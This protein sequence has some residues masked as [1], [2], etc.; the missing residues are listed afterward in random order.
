MQPYA[1]QDEARAKIPTQLEAFYKTS[2]PAV[3]ATK[4]ALV[5]A[6]GAELR[7]SIARTCFPT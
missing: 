2:N 4:A 3:L 5:K 7:R 1:S 6:A